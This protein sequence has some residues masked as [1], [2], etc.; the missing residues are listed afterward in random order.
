MKHGGVVEIEIGCKVLPALSG[1]EYEQHQ[2][3]R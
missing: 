2:S 3:E 1:K